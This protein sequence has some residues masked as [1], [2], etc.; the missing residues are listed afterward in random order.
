MTVETSPVRTQNFVVER[1]KPCVRGRARGRVRGSLLSL[2]GLD[3]HR[4]TATL[5]RDCQGQ[6]QGKGQ[7]AHGVVDTTAQQAER[8]IHCGAEEDSLRS[9]RAPELHPRSSG[10]PRRRGAWSGWSSASPAHRSNFP[11]EQKGDEGR[12]SETRASEEGSKAS[13]DSGGGETLQLPYLPWSRAGCGAAECRTGAWACGEGSCRA[14]SGSCGSPV[15]RSKGGQGSCLSRLVTRASGVCLMGRGGLGAARVC[16]MGRGGLGAA[17]VC[18]MGRGS[19]GAAR[20]CL[21]GRG[22]LGAARVCL[23][24]RGTMGAA[25]IT[26]DRTN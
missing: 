26:D 10:Q 13:R 18:L 4:L 7:A 22:G 14:S 20:V 2:L 6:W 16:L 15:R 3:R 1:M 23:T 25:W 12:H 24:G 8:R 17:R 5:R 11:V 21:M 19:L 9:R